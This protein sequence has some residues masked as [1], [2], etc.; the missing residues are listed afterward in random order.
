MK[1]NNW[2]VMNVFP[3]LSEGKSGFH[4]KK[5]NIKWDVVFCCRPKKDDSK[6]KISKKRMEKWI[7][8][9]LNYWTTRFEKNNLNFSKSDEN[10]LSLALATAYISTTN[11]DSTTIN[12]LIKEYS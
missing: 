8:N 5:G 1:E 6:I 10:S 7:T 9:R 12:H 11:A 4:S 2:Q 3:V